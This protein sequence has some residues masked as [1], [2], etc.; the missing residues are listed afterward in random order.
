MAE[1]PQLSIVNYRKGMYIVLQGN[2][3][4]ERF[5]IIQNGTVQLSK[6]GAPVTREAGNHTLV[7]GDFFGVVSAMAQKSQ[8]ETA[9]A[10]A[11][12]TL[13]AVRRNQFEGLIQYNT[14]IAMKIIRQFSRRMRYL[15]NELA[16]ITLHSIGEFNQSVFL[17]AAD[18]YFNK[19]KFK[20]AVYI[21]NRYLEAYPDG[22]D[23]ELAKKRIADSAQFNV[24][25]FQQGKTPFHRVYA[26]ETPVF[27]EGEVGE[28]LFI[29]QSGSVKITRVINND[30]V[31]LSLL[32]P[33]DIFG[34]MAILESEPRSASAITFENTTL[35]VIHQQNF[36]GMSA[37][38]PQ[39]IGRLTQLLAERIWFGYK[40]IE[41]AAIKDPLGR[42]YDYLLIQLE[43]NNF[44]V[45][46][47]ASYT[48]SFGPEEL[49]KMASI[50]E[51]EIRR[52][53]SEI[54]RNPKMSVMNDGK[55]YVSDVTE[56]AKLSDF[57][58]KLLGRGGRQ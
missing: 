47:R 45:Q 28:E 14:P 55:L 40:Q 51:N 56:L 32:R 41:N 5:F 46:P 23:A 48:F 3:E 58:K 1:R 20:L 18:F 8:I 49:A 34:E 36:E 43:R 33:G 12:T 52:V 7:A 35:M 50:P 22:R 16:N 31:I 10:S 24:P 13:V 27:V 29:I 53:T 19:K 17:V 44:V 4:S 21:Y 6:D 25:N 9:Q 37:T 54:S 57:Y 30:E 26:G 38:Q 11:D 39:I 15:N 2:R 42:C